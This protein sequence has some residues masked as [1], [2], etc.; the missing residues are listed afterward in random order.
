MRI[1]ITILLPFVIMF[2][3]EVCYEAVAKRIWPKVHREEWTMEEGMNEG[4]QT[5]IRM[6]TFGALGVL[7]TLA[8]SLL[9]F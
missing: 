1:A 7:A 3:L 4:C 8:L 5:T 6:I 2:F 9:G